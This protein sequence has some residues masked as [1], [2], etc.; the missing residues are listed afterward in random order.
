MEKDRILIRSEDG[1]IRKD[2]YITKFKFMWK[3]QVIVTLRARKLK[4]QY[5]MLIFIL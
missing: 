1:A 3:N 5:I 4:N 2:G